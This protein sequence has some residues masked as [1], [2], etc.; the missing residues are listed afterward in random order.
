MRD[1][2]KSMRIKKEYTMKD[3]GKRLGISESYYCAIENGIRQQRMDLIFIGELAAV[4]D[5]SISEIIGLEQDWLIKNTPT[6]EKRFSSSPE[7]K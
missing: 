2:L 3:M 5:V 6:K 7:N 4:F 1:W